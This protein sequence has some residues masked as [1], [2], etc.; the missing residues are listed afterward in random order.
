MSIKEITLDKSA[1]EVI[2]DNGDL[3]NL[4]RTINISKDNL[5]A[6]LSSKDLSELLVKTSISN[7]SL[8]AL[9]SSKDLSELLKIVYISTSSLEVLVTSSEVVP[10]I[11]YTGYIAGSVYEE[12]TPTDR[13]LFLY[14]EDD[15]T[16]VSSTTSSSGTG[17]YSFPTT[18]GNYF[19]VC[20]DNWDGVN[21]NDL[22]IR[23]LR[24]EATT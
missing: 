20:L 17:S 10:I 19:I 5:E 24:P 8:E 16:L 7:E 11:N 23:G 13:K 22:I 9:L 2:I 21:Y 18:S 4:L 6:L 12:G 14:T 1:I 15:K 3:T